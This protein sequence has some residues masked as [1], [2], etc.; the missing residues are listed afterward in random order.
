MSTVAF[1]SIDAYHAQF[2]QEVKTRL[3]KLFQILQQELPGAEICF[4]YNM[5]TFRYTK[6]VV[7]YAA[8]TAHIGFYPTPKPILFFKKELSTFKTSKG[9][10]QFQH[11]QPM[12][13]ELIKTIVRYRLKQ[14]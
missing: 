3:Q 9:A 11:N 1:K 10:I 6:N 7:H 12:P 4:R 5:P 8:F 13:W 14:V 2:P